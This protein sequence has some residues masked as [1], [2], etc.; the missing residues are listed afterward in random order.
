MCQSTFNPRAATMPPL[1]S[2]GM[3]DLPIRMSHPSHIPHPQF[4]QDETVY[5]GSSRFDALC[6]AAK[7]RSVQRRAMARGVVGWLEACGA[8]KPRNRFA[9]RG[10]G[11]GEEQVEQVQQKMACR[12][13]PQR[14]TSC[15]GLPPH[16]PAVPGSLGMRHGRRPPLTAERPEPPGRHLV[17]NGLV[18]RCGS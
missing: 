1:R 3:L 9:H 16:R 14:V 2:T 18:S 10:S 6:P 13:P 8:S 11:G 17:G 15:N 5:S 4:A 12:L 7:P